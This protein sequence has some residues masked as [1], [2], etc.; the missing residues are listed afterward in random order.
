VQPA[1]VPSDLISFRIASWNSNIIARDNAA[2]I[3]S[4]FFHE[5]RMDIVLLQE[6]GNLAGVPHEATRDLVVFG[7]SPVKERIFSPGILVHRRASQHVVWSRHSEH[8]CL[9]CMHV[10]CH[11]T[12]ETFKRILFASV[13]LPDCAKSFE[14]F[15]DAL[16]EVD[17]LLDEVWSSPETAWDLLLLAGDLNIEIPVTPLTGK[18]ASA[19]EW[20]QRSSAVYEFSLKWHLGWEVSLD[21]D[22]YSHINYAD[23]HTSTLDYVLMSS[24]AGCVASASFR[25]EIELCHFSDHI[26]LV[27]NLTISARR[28]KRKQRPFKP[29]LDWKDPLL[30]NKFA[31]LLLE[32]NDRGALESVNDFQN[33]FC[34]SLKLL[35]S[36]SRP[37]GVHVPSCSNIPVSEQCKA[38]RAALAEA[39]S[40][41]MR[42]QA[43]RALSAKKRKIR[44]AREAAQ[45]ESRALHAPREDKQSGPVHSLCIQ[46]K[47][48]FDPEQWRNE[49]VK[50]YRQLFSDP[51]NNED[52]QLARLRSLHEISQSSD[53]IFLPRWIVLEVFSQ[54][55]RKSKTAPGLDGVC[56]M[57]LSALPEDI[58]ENLRF[59]LREA[60]KRRAEPLL[61]HS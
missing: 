16:R 55:S 22:Q 40:P 25:P 30:R 19:Q 61:H 38:E 29:K 20:N 37:Y 1:A 46:D 2:C 18:A 43:S 7:C 59:A 24:A 53:K 17:A 51:S 26:P 12:S 3:L 23:K 36:E 27:G 54:C 48:V 60:H 47:I 58:I 44:N 11:D 45:F 28:A 52:V 15:S 49:F 6:P 33:S 31:A 41:E 34:K 21:H 8:I 57:L 5:H 9:V 42:L 35:Q 32:D 14:V 39:T 13:Y 56:W 50:L 4:D 10:V